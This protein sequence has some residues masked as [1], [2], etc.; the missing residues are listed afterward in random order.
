[1]K[2]AVATL[3]LLAAVASA[4]TP[5]R[6]HLH[7]PRANTTDNMT[8]VTVKATKVQT[9]TSCAPTVTNC[10]ARA[11]EIAKLPEAQRIVTTVTDT[12]VLTE[13]VCPLTEADRVSSSVMAQAS[14]GSLSG[15]ISHPSSAAEHVATTLPANATAQPGASSRTLTMTLGVGN[16]ASR[17]TTVVPVTGSE[18]VVPGSQTV[19][20]IES[21]PTTTVTSTTRITHTITVSRVHPTASLGGG[22][23]GNNGAG[24][25]SGGN[26][27]CVPS[28]VTV[29]ER[30]IT[31]PASTVYVTIGG[32]VPT[33]AGNGKSTPT[34]G[35]GNSKSTPT[36]GAGD[37][38][39]TPTPAA[40]KDDEDSECT[41]DTTTLQKTLTVVPY[42]TGNGTHNSGSPKPSGSARL[43]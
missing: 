22:K 32:P 1:M 21:E 12:T 14:A 7:F 4:Y 37:S 26:G 43:R 38:K 35:A 3:G 19:A 30:T 5:G 31:I 27:E 28:T 34:P 11:S 6:R 24:N 10:P 23:S 39:S 36:P 41:S 9:I 25:G 17:V 42:P 29:A 20:P 33:D 40:D 13:I 16:T 15:F 18:P 2:S 8:T